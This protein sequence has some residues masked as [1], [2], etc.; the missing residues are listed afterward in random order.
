VD[1]QVGLGQ[2]KQTRDPIWFKLMSRCPEYREFANF[3]NLH[4]NL[5]QSFWVIQRTGRG[6]TIMLDGNFKERYLSKVD[7]FIVK[8][9]KKKG[10]ENEHE[11][12]DCLEHH[13]SR[14]VNN[15]IVVIRNH[16]HIFS[17]VR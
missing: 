16:R 4:E 3:R 15:F 8:L 6:F 13:G 1:G 7:H 10:K 5:F 14:S 12:T 2:Q 17:C 11:R 9:P